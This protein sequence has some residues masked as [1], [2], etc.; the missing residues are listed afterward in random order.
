[1]GLLGDLT[2]DCDKYSAKWIKMTSHKNKL[3]SFAKF[4]G[5]VFTQYIFSRQIMAYF[6]S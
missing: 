4:F 3:T 2:V 5:Q 6:K 1:M